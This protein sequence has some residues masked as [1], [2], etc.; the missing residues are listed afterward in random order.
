MPAASVRGSLALLSFTACLALAVRATAD[1]P[2]LERFQRENEVAA[3]KVETDVNKMLAE[4]RR[5]EL[6]NPDRARQLLTRARALLTDVRG[7]AEER[8]TR[9]LALVDARVRSVEATIRQQQAAADRTAAQDAERERQREKERVGTKS[10]RPADQARDFINKGR[11]QLGGAY[12]EKVRRAKGFNEVFRDIERSSVP[13]TRDVTF[14]KDWAA[15][16]ALRKKRF[17]PQLTQ[18][19]KNL[20]KA[21]NSTLSLEFEKVAFR[22]VI[23]YLQEKTGTTIIVDRASMREAEVEYDDPVNFTAP[24]ITFRTA[25]RKIL[26]DNHLSYVLKDGIIEV[27]TPQKA[28]EMMVVRNYPIDAFLPAGGGPFNFVNMVAAQQIIDLITT[29]IEPSIWAVNGG[30]AT[31]TFNPGT[32]SLVIRAPA[33]MQYMLGGSLSK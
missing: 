12:G 11:D 6:S 17:E 26:A 18:A 14:P 1:G 2:D 19:E 15:R 5:L 22:D 30:T 21:L 16:S 31:I 13:S 9:L 4:A 3:Q 29:S 23:N 25:L 8:R 7:M 28:R 27:V 10:Q 20:I 24:K 32:Q 33:E